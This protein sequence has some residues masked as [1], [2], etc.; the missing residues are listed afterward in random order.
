MLVKH[1]GRFIH[2]LYDANSDD[3]LGSEVLV[4]SETIGLCIGTFG[5]YLLTYYYILFGEQ[6]VVIHFGYLEPAL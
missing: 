1:I 3:N 2:C 5:A 4:E 6:I